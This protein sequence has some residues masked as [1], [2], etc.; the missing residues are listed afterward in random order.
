MAMAF[1][2]TVPILNLLIPVVGTAA[3][4]HVLDQAVTLGQ[5][6]WNDTIADRCG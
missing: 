1:A 2:G 4:V 5:P 3:M 6:A